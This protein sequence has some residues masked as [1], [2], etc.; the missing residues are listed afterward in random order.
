MENETAQV[1]I[2]A[3]LS[4]FYYYYFFLF[5]CFLCVYVWKGGEGFVLF[6]HIVANSH[7]AFPK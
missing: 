7:S 1:R 6:L 2:L 3:G 4:Y 5:V